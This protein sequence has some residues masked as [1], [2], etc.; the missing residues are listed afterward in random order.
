MKTT[1]LASMAAVAL[2]GTSC[3]LF[4]GKQF[5][6]TSPSSLD[7][8]ML[9]KG[10]MSSYYAERGGA[11]TG[12]KPLTPFSVKSAASPSRATVPIY[13]QYGNALPF[14][15]LTSP[16]TIANY[17]EP[18]Q[19][20]VFTAVPYAIDG[21]NNVYDV[22]V[23]TTYPSTDVRKSYVEKYYVEDSADAD[24]WTDN[25]PIV[26]T[27][28]GSWAPDP[29]YRAK[30]LLT[31]QD[32][33]TR[34][35]TIVSTSTAG[36]PYFD[37]TSFAISGSLDMNQAFIPATTTGNPGGNGV[38]YSSVVMYYV[39]PSTNYN[40]W[41]WQ[42][43][44]SNTILGV[45][46]Y[47]EVLSGSTYTDYTV[48]F[49]KTV[50]TLTTT[51]GSFTTTLGSVYAGSQ[52]T[53]L[54]ESVLRQQVAYNA[55]SGTPDLSTGTATTNMQTRVVNIAGKKD[56]YLSQLN[57]DDVQLS[58]WATSTIYAPSGDATEIAAADPTTEVFARNQQTS[59]I[60]GTLPFAIQTSDVA[61]YGDLG[62]LYTSIVEGSATS[63]VSVAP[64]SN[65]MPT[66]TEY[67]FNGQ[68]YKGAIV[69]G[70]TSTTNLTSGTIQAW[71]YVKQQTDTAGVIHKG[72]SVDFSDEC[73]SLQGWGSSGQ[74]AIVLDQPGTGNSYDIVASTINLNTGKWYYLVA[75]WDT[76]TKKICL[77]IN[78]A[79]NNSGTM[80]VTSS[81]VRNNTSDILVGSQLPSSYSSAYGY[82][83]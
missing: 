2:L 72:T 16:T 32:G 22:T 7:I 74:F 21:S 51:G 8:A 42:G 77:Y 5:G 64:A 57:S 71:I 76:S 50:G 24:T 48:S 79:L 82:F 18:G 14:A 40:F 6:S 59:A 29:M 60:T 69:T 33:S 39:N 83:G 25:D 75:T 17:P 41:F 49:E 37:P 54:A 30:M 19:T 67:Q 15:G 1:L 65:L 61:G 10:F 26:S 81:G 34:N 3:A 52:F 4:M 45:R 23:T 11:P 27:Q 36:G 62:T 66:G 9:Q 31:F 12:N 13:S 80:N 70:G 68:Q 43:N 44:S 20:S 55:P 28:T 53:T 47:T 78:G 56:F 46:Y 63:S 35:E 38:Q 58:S 73:Y